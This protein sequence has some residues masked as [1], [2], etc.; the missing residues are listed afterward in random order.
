MMLSMFVNDRRDNWNEL[1]PF[2]MHAYRTS[3]HESTGYSSGG[4][5]TDLVTGHSVQL[6]TR[7]AD[8]Q[9]SATGGEITEWIPIQVRRGS[10][11]TESPPVDEDTE[12]SPLRDEEELTGTDFSR[13]VQP[14]VTST[15]YEDPLRYEDPMMQISGTGHWFLEGWIG[16]HSVEFLVDSGSSV[17]A[18]TCWR[19]IGHSPIYRENATQ[20]KWQMVL[21]RLPHE[22]S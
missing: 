16:D 8:I 18:S 15:R 7:M 21:A 19:P 4:S 10:T 14:D 5:T 20:R 9:T 11:E 2:V 13:D 3:V 6:P 1:L 17:T 22:R 12:Q